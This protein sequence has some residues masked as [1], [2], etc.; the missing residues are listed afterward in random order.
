[1]QNKSLSFKT[2]DRGKSPTTKS[3]SK[4]VVEKVVLVIKPAIDP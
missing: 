1:M 3:K 2:A 4:K